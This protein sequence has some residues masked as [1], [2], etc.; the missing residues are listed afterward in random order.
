MKNRAKCKKCQSVIESYHT[1]DYVSCK[2]DEISVSG[3][4]AMECAAK[5]W[6]NFVRVDDLGNEIIPKIKDNV[7]PLDISAPPS[8]EEL[9]RLLD[10]MIVRMEELPTNAM[11]QPITHYDLASA[12]ILIQSILKTTSSCA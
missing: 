11:L 7:K 10:E 6:A 2:C 8:K 4:P 12:L 5:D 9:L 3:G 1:Y